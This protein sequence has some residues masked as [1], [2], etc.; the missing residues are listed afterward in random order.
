[1]P[2]ISSPLPVLVLV[3]DELALGLA[4]PLDDDLLGGLGGDAPEAAAGLPEVQQ[5][6]VL[7]VLLAGLVGV[8]VEVEDL[9]AEILTDLRVGEAVA[10]GVGEG[11]LLLLVLDLLDHRHP[12]DEV[13]V[14]RLLVV[15]G[16]Q[17]AADAELTLRRR[18][19]GLLHRLDEDLLIEALLATDL[20][21]DVVQ[22]HA[23]LHV[24]TFAKASSR[25]LR[26]EVRLRDVG[27]GNGVG[28]TVHLEV[29]HGGVFTGDH[30]QAATKLA[31]GGGAVGAFDGGPGLE[32]HLAA[33]EALV[34]P[35]PDQGTVEARR[36]DLEAVVA[37]RHLVDL[38]GR[39]EV[40]AHRLAVGEGDAVA[41]APLAALPVQRDPQD[42]TAALRHR[43]HEDQLHAVGGA[44][45][46][47]HGGDGL[48]VDGGAHGKEWFG[49][50]R[51]EGVD[52]SRG[53][54]PVSGPRAPWLAPLRD[55]CPGRGRRGRRRQKWADLVR[56]TQALPRLLAPEEL[57][58]PG[59]RG[60]GGGR[61]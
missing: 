40:P 48:E 50:T 5:V 32:A 30:G 33:E 4:D 7:P 39:T 42:H 26:N 43:L 25:E 2:V 29:D 10:P 15:A 60:N 44:D 20:L 3:V 52:E 18:H 22:R 45:R 55:A 61:A 54:R 34:V 27:E 16:L 53:R 13:D 57:T 49:T 19:D 46:L 56:P 31:T 24:F 47:R 37:G 23:S 36:A 21:D 6:A 14:A 38:E 8:G 17:L 12:L 9:E 11:D 28:P 1:M 35:L 59:T 41:G 58:R 51:A